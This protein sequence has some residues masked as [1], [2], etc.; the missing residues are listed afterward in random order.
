[1]SKTPDHANRD[2]ATYGPSSM[3]RIINCPA[4][5]FYGRNLPA[6]PPSKYASEGHT[7]HECSEIMLEARLEG[8]PYP[9]VDGT[10]F[11]AEMIRHAKA[12]ADYV[13]GVVEHALYKSHSYFIERRVHL[14]RDRDI[15]GTAD[16]VMIYEEGDVLKLVLIDY[17][18][19][20]GVAVGAD[21]N[22]QL[23]TYALAA[24]AEMSTDKEVVDVEC[25][26]FQPRADHETPPITYNF[27]ELKE[28]YLPTILETVDKIESWVA[29]GDIPKADLQTGYKTGSWCQFCKVKDHGECGL[30]RQ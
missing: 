20:A 30:Y 17:K 24:E 7:A 19:G 26:I 9:E 29:A 21:E 16:F 13:Y 27:K 5:Y 22:W 15:W 1:M 25:H 14:D 12:Y 28:K 8:K 10:K 23:I 4:A 3:K 11:N 2:H 18:Y 6:P